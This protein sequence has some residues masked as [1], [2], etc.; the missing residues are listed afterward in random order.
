MYQ[1]AQIGWH[2]KFAGALTVWV[3]GL[4][5]EIDVESSH[6][7]HG[8]VRLEVN[9]AI[10]GLYETIMDVAALSRFYQVHVTLSLHRRQIGVLLIRRRTSRTLDGGNN[11][12]Y[13]SLATKSPQSNAVTYPTGQFT[14]PDDPEFSVSYTYSG[15]LINS[16]DIFLVVLDTLATAAQFSRATSFTSFHAISPSGDCVISIVAI[17]ATFQ[18]NYSFVTKAL[19]IMILE[20]MVQLKK[21]GEI[22]LQLRWQTSVMAEL[23]IKLAGR[24]AVA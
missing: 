14:D 3:E 4:N 20:I 6:M 18:V 8:S 22:S 17:D 9:H 16:K 2:E 13:L 15:A 12:T 1:F 21:F 19:R 11:A 7:S 23:S 10:F 5:V 24:G